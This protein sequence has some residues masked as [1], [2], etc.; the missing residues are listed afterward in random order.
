MKACK[1]LI[2]SSHPF[3]HGISHYA[4]PVLSSP[5]IYYTHTHTKETPPPHPNLIVPPS[6]LLLSQNSIVNAAKKHGISFLPSTQ[7]TI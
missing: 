1:A 2:H 7:Y 5:H 3:Q 4:N 6:P